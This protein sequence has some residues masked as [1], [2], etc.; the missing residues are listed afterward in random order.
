MRDD[1]AQTALTDR[2]FATLAP[3]E[4][5]FVCLTVINEFAW[6][7]ERTYGLDRSTVAEGIRRLLE[8]ADIRI[9]REDL[10]AWALDLYL[11]EKA[12][13]ADI[14]IGEINREAGCTTTY[15]FDKFAARPPS[16]KTLSSQS[17]AG[18]P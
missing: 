7:L 9:E 6:V 17:L 18:T 15:T 16:M 12:D 3:G 10:V 4:E 8:A 1:R 2:L 5:G 13:L 14:L 11:V